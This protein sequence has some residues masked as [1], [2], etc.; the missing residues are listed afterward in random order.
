MIIMHFLKSCVTLLT[1]FVLAGCATSNMAEK[2]RSAI[3]ENATTVK[4]YAEMPSGELYQA[5]YR[6]LRQEGFRFA[7]T[8]EDM[9]DL[10]TEG[11][12]VGKSQTELRI[13]LFVESSK[14]G[15]VLTANAE[16]ELMPG[17]WKPVAFKDSGTKYKVG[18][19]ELVLLMQKIPHQEMEYVIDQDRADRA[20]GIN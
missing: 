16:Y 12:N 7:R 9:Q 6:T 18:F 5:A 10:S 20:F 11:K 17:N 8:N 13:D 1:I 4:L 3:P 19:E 15:S 14:N 2:T